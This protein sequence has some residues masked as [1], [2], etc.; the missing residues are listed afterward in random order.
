MSG[1]HA[2]HLFKRAQRGLFAGKMKMFGNKISEE[3]GNKTRRCWNP[4][5]QKKKL[6]SEILGESFKLNVTT[7]ALRCIDKAGGLDKYLLNT[8]DKDLNSLRGQQIRKKIQSAM[9]TTTQE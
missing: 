1:K 4:N 7:H 5:V 6:F 8:T 3:G 2:I 9:H